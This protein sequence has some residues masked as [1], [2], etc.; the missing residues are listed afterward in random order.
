[1]I[2]REYGQTGKKVSALGFGGMRFELV[3]DLDACTEMVLT[4]ANGG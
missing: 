1:M 4:A 3:D 2:Y